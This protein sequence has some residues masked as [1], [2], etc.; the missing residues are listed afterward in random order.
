[1]LDLPETEQE[2]ACWKLTHSVDFVHHYGDVV[3][4]VT[5]ELRSDLQ[6]KYHAWAKR[7][8]AMHPERVVVELDNTR[9]DIGYSIRFFGMQVG[10]ARG[11]SDITDIARDHFLAQT[12]RT[13]YVNH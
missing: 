5:P 8:F 12:H 6:R 9:H 1:M 4:P 10:V 2:F 13:Y 7:I 3:R 11:G